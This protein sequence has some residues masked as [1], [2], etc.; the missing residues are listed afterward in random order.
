MLRG[1]DISVC[2]TL[3]LKR[4]LSSILFS[5]CLNIYSYDNVIWW[6]SAQEFDQRTETFTHICGGSVKLAFVLSWTIFVYLPVSSMKAQIVTCMVQV[7]VIC[8]GVCVIVCVY[9]STQA[10]ASDSLDLPKCRLQVT[11]QDCR[12]TPTSQTACKSQRC[13][14]S[15]CECTSVWLWERVETKW[16]WERKR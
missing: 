15:V 1:C 2:L 10:M 9:T 12:I 16:E 13:M 3:H 6:K 14:D 8:K 7:T 4:S 11:K 5:K